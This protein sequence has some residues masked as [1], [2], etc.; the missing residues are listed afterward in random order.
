MLIR[1]IILNMLCDPG[2]EVVLK[3]AFDELMEQI[4]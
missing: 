3:S 1:M 4:R 2:D